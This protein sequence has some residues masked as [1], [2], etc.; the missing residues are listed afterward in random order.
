MD[1][2]DLAFAGAARQTEL[3][4]RREVSARELVQLY[5]DRIAR[6]DPLLNA[7]RVVLAEQALASAE[8]ADARAAA[9]DQR[10]LLGVPI[11][12]KDDCDVSGEATAFGSDAHDGPVPADAELVRRLRAAGAVIL[13]KTHVPELTITP[14]TESPT[15]GVTR[16][17]WDPQRTPG[18]TSGGSAAAVAAGLAGAAIGSDGAGSIRIPAGCCGLFGLKAQNGSVPTAPMVEPWNGMSMWGPITRGVA[19]SAL[20]YDVLRGG[21]PSWV[22]A[23]ASPPDRL[24]IAVSVATPPFTGVQA[25]GEQLGAVWDTVERLRSLGHEVIEREITYPLPAVANVVA[26]YLRGIADQ[27]RSMPHPERL[28]RRARGYVRMG[29]AIPLAALSR[30]RAAAGADGRA[31]DRV[32]DGGVDLVMTPMFTRRA[33][34]VRAY[35]GRGALWALNGSI[36]FVPYCAAYNHTGQPAAAVPAGWTPDGFPLSVQLVAPPG[37][38]A[39]LLGL[40]AQLEASSGW[41]DRRPALAA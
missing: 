23:A 34:L 35:E 22:S 30:A 4:R 28:S 33:P 18:G 7:Y 3:I 41:L 19:D 17:P 24:R 26:R 38:E 32:F 11:A 8:Q 36:R 37:G 25:D 12:I 13:G 6:L 9:G 10:P 1:A 31:L 14:W 40:A 27:G 29:S 39:G 20:V 5:L 21:G 2:T 15:Y 16:N